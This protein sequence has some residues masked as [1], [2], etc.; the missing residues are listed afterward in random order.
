LRQ[1]VLLV[2]FLHHGFAHLYCN[3]IKYTYCEW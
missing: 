1:L 2:F 3:S